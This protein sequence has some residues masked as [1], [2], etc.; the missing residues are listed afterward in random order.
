MPLE[1]SNALRERSNGSP[2][3]SDALF[4]RSIVLPERSDGGLADFNGSSNRLHGPES[5][6]IVEFDKNMSQ[7]SHCRGF[8][9]AST[10]PTLLTR[11]SS[12][13]VHT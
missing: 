6:M 10:R 8:T 13:S 3:R 4:E 12:V 2:E 11:T 7:S 9:D 5:T 1:R